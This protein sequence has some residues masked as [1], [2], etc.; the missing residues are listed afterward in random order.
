MRGWFDVETH[1][2][3]DIYLT[4]KHI[5]YYDVH[6]PVNKPIMI[7]LTPEEHKTVALWAAELETTISCLVRRTL[8]LPQVQRGRPRVNRAK[9]KDT[10]DVIEEAVKT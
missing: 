6:M 7:Y 3:F 10:S 9:P 4:L 1:I 2:I 5:L 8:G